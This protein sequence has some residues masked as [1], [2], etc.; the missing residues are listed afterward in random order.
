MGVDLTSYQ[1]MLKD[2]YSDARVEKF[3]Y[4]EQPF[5]AWLPKAEDFGGKRYSM[6]LQHETPVG[7]SP[8]FADAQA[9]KEG[10]SY[11]DFLV[12]RAKLYGLLSLDN[13]SMDASDMNKGA[14]DKAR[15]REAKDLF[16]SV[17]EKLGK[18]V[19]TNHGGAIGTIEADPSGY[20]SGS[21]FTLA[22][23]DDV[24][25]FKI[26][27]HY[28]HAKTD[29]TS[30]AVGSSGVSITPTN[31]DRDTGVVTF[32]VVS[33]SLV[34][35]DMGPLQG[36]PGTVYFFLRGG[37]GL[38][39]AGVDSWIPAST[40]GLSTP[41]YTVDRSV[42]PTRMAGIRF[43]GTGYSAFDALEKGL[44]RGRRE[45]A[46]PDTIWV[47]HERF[48]DFSIQLGAKVERPTVK[49]GP[50]GFDSI[51][52]HSGGKPVKIMADRHVPY[53]VAYAL[54]R[55]TWKFRS[56]KKAPRFL[57]GH[58][59]NVIPEATSD[60]IELRVGL[61]G[62]VFCNAPGRNIRIALPA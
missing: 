45:E 13:E 60:G 28:Q 42:D 41:F 52:I 33:G 61:Y 9:N 20:T 10:S 35:N 16:L 51:Q 36:T 22:N 43:D 7:I 24:V 31:I 14:W 30:G 44:A 56:L 54:T 62:N 25:N 11:D 6:P 15:L 37:F 58:N 39:F 27:Q 3:C 46:M 2:Y 57:W 8:T 48:T 26:G 40:S 47:N 53:D 50:V 23:V 59:G 17:A 55:S 49:L 32:D 18:A 19:F 12:T 29:G 34:V 5:W 4:Q 21:T 1:A 38:G